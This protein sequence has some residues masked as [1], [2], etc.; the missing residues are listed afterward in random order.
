MDKMKLGIVGIGMVGT[1]L[2]RWFIEKGWKRGETLFCYDADPKKNYFDDINQAHI[3]F[4]CVPTPSN[5]DGSCN[6]SILESVI[7]NLPD[8]ARCIVIKSTVPPGT[9]VDLQNKYVNKGFFLFNPEFL[10]E[11]HAGKDFLNPDRQIVAAADIENR[12]SQKWA[13]IVLDILPAVKGTLKICDVSSTEAELTKYAA[14]VFGALK[15]IYFNILAK[16]C[17]FL[18][19]NYEKVRKMVTSDKRIGPSWSIV[20]Y[21]GYFGYGGFCFIKDTDASITSDEKLLSGL[22]ESEREVFSK[23]I[24]FFK[25]MRVFNESLLELQGLTLEDV[26]L[27]D[28]ELIK[29]LRVFKEEEKE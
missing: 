17:A 25:A 5:S 29:K 16:R 23:A 19:A 1:P 24:E 13:K 11:A 22:E 4:I 18:G 26:C 7:E 15:V 2:M 3:I 27:H 9:T 8:K 10:T 28:K 21:N 14:N 12:I 6:T 20:P